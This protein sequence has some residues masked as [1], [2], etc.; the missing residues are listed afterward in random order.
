ML[1]DTFKL[2]NKIVARNLTHR[3]LHNLSGVPLLTLDN[4]FTQRHKNMRATTINKLCGALHI[5]P[6]D[7]TVPPD[8]YQDY[9]LERYAVLSSKQKEMKDKGLDTAA[10]VIGQELSKIEKQLA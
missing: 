2:K 5:A 8:E 1:I 4:M 7:I 3:E 6:D 10:S 9:L